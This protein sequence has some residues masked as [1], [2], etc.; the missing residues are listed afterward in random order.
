MLLKWSVIFSQEDALKMLNIQEGFSEYYGSD[1]E[2]WIKYFWVIH[3]VWSH[4]CVIAK[5]RGKACEKWKREKSAFAFT[6]NDVLHMWVLAAD[7]PPLSTLQAGLVLKFMQQLS[8]F[9]L[10]SWVRDPYQAQLQG[11]KHGVE[12]VLINI[13]R[14]QPFPPAHSFSQKL[15]HV[16]CCVIYGA[17]LCCF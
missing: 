6:Y 4:L 14:H 3:H 15:W 16:P 5:P 7:A 1:R 17:D 2:Y 9:F 8:L 12:N 10:L 13:H 11:M